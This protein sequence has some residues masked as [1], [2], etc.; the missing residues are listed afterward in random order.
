MIMNV[1]TVLKL[2]YLLFLIILYH[3][4]FMPKNEKTFPVSDK[5]PLLHNKK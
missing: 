1:G 5:Q 2:Q 3:I 4:P